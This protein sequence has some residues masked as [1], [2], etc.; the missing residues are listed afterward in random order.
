MRLLTSAAEEIDY[1]STHAAEMYL[2]LED[3]EKIQFRTVYRRELKRVEIFARNSAV[4]IH[5]M[6]SGRIQKI[7]METVDAIHDLICKELEE[8]SV[9]EK[10]QKLADFLGTDKTFEDMLLEGKERL[11]FYADQICEVM[12]NCLRKTEILNAQNSIIQ[13]NVEEEVD[14]LY[15]TYKKMLLKV[16]VSALKKAEELPETGFWLKEIKTDF[17]NLQKEFLNFVVEQYPVSLK[18]CIVSEEGEK[19]VP[20]YIRDHAFDCRPVQTG[21]FHL[22]PVDWWKKQPSGVER[23]LDARK[24]AVEEI[25]ELYFKQMEEQI[26]KVE[27]RYTRLRQASYENEMGNYNVVQDTCRSLKHKLHDRYHFEYDPEPL[28]KIIER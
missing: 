3:V 17:E 28:E 25:S 24:E 23:D 22:V 6:G 21:N 4:D 14:L 8:S 12:E 18:K 11:E 20:L 13:K 9:Q 19:G 16:S 1:L 7:L 5:A 15:D 2:M 10:N 27:H 26:I